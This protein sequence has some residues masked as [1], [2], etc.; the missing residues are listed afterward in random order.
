[1]TPELRER[2]GEAATRGATAINYVGAG[3]IEM[4]LDEDGSF[5]FMEMNTRIQVEHPVTEQLTGVDLVK[6]QIRVAAG[7]PLSVKELP[8]FRGHVIE[9]RVNAEDPARKFLPSPGTITRLR[10]PSGPGVRWDSGYH[11]GDTVSQYY[12]NLIGKLVVWAPDRDR[13]IARM[14]RALEEFEVAGLSTT[15]PAHLALLQHPD[16]ATTDLA[17]LRS[18]DVGG[19]CRPDFSG[20]LGHPRTHKRPAMCAPGPGAMKVRHEQANYQRV[21]RQVRG[22]FAQAPGMHQP[23]VAASYRSC[24]RRWSNSSTAPCVGRANASNWLLRTSSADGH[25]PTPRC[26]EPPS[27]GRTPRPGPRAHRQWQRQ[28]MRISSH[29]LAKS[30]WCKKPVKKCK[31]A[32]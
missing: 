9:C 22:Q 5:F 17:R 24:V 14:V 8:P 32:H 2:M 13:A 30:N 25:H 15:I 11:E 6:E 16:F 18:A 20:E 12:D 29:C 28:E 23:D 7:L 26:P 19:A 27:A 10:V 4:L 21:G 3:T 1:M 31:R